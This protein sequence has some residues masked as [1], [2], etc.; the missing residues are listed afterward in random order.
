MLCLLP[1]LKTNV[2]VGAS[3]DTQFDNLLTDMYE[4]ALRTVNVELCKICVFM[5]ICCISTLVVSI[6]GMRTNMCMY[7]YLHV[8]THR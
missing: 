8:Q 3:C 4:S 7:L 6:I 5:D 1:A 2:T